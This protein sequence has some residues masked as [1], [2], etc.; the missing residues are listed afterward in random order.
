MQR[1]IASIDLVPRAE[2]DISALTMCVSREGLLRLKQRVQDFRRELVGLEGADGRGEIVVQV[3][4]QL[5]P[6][7][8][9]VR[10]P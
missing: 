9:T 10:E 4:F 7:T 2:R 6:L 8:Q 1:A 5:Y 3:N